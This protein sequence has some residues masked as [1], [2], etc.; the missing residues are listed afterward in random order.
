MLKLDRPMIFIDDVPSTWIFEHYLKLSEKLTGQTVKILSVFKKERTPSMCL[1]YNFDDKC[2]KFKDFSSGLSGNGPSLVSSLYGISY[3]N[4]VDKILKDYD[5]YLKNNNFLPVD[6]CLKEVSIKS[7]YQ[8]SSVVLRKWNTAD[9]NYW[10][11]YGINSNLLN[12]HNVKPIKSYAMT[13]TLSDNTQEVINI[14]VHGIYGYYNSKGEL[15]KIY[16]PHQTKKKFIK[17]QDYIQGSDQMTNA[18]YL[19]ITSS[20]KDLLAF[21]ALG[22]KGIDAIAPDSENSLIP[23]DYMNMLKTKYTKIFTMF[24]DDSAGIKAMNRYEELYQIPCIHVQMSKDLSDSV[25]DYGIK[26]VKVV[27]FHMLKALK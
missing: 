6:L 25:K 1:Y 26:N 27:M 12:A 23:E 16:Q 4:A 19:I 15:C 7:K 17:V 8:V 18:K 22:F 21:K 13:R 10:L 20:L 11:K 24:D 3:Y 2:Y 9:A 14:D 5:Q